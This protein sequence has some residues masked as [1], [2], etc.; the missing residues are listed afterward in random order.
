MPAGTSNSTLHERNTGL[1]AQLR[2]R[3]ADIAALR[4]ECARL[5]QLSP[6]A[7]PV[8]TDGG[9]PLSEVCVCVCARADAARMAQANQ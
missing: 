8:T 4:A 3:Q 9:P 5:Q 6:G 1:E 2:A 7:S